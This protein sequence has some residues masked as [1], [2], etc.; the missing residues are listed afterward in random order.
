[1]RNINSDEILYVRA[2]ERA[3]S[4]FNAG[5]SLL[6]ILIDAIALK[7]NSKGFK[8]FAFVWTILN[9]IDHIRMIIVN[10]RSRKQALDVISDEELAEEARENSMLSGIIKGLDHNGI[11]YQFTGKVDI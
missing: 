5:N 1:M 7:S 6:T 3:V 4:A 10:L 8:I 2:E 11:K 9:A